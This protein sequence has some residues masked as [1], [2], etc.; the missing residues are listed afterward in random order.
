[1]RRVRTSHIKP[2][3]AMGDEACGTS[4]PSENGQLALADEVPDFVRRAVQIGF[5]A[6]GAWALWRQI[7]KTGREIR[8]RRLTPAG[9]ARRVDRLALAVA[10][11]KSAG[12]AS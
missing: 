6:D 9:G 2:I 5:D 10:I 1:M 11:A 7:T 8:A 4:A 3:C 12:V